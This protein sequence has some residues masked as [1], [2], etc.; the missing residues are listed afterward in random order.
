[1]PVEGLCEGIFFK[2]WFIKTFKLQCLLL[3]YLPEHVEWDVKGRI[4][5]VPVLMCTYN[6]YNNQL[7]WHFF[8]LFCLN[9]LNLNLCW[10]NFVYKH[11]N[12]VDSLQ[13]FLWNSADTDS[14]V[15]MFKG[16]ESSEYDTDWSEMHISLWTDGGN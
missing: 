3:L 16:D 12:S 10:Q 1:M 8:F 2:E 15:I 11:L 14:V 4:Q 6:Q 13:W 5:N 7:F 9:Q